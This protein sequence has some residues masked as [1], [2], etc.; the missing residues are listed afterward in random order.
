MTKTATIYALSTATGRGAVAI[1]RLSGPLALSALVT[2]GV[3]KEGY[4]PRMATRVV[5]RDPATGQ[6]LDDA[7]ATYFR[8]PNSF[9]GEDVVELH[10]HGGRAVVEGVLSA[11]AKIEGLRLAEAGEFTR[12]AFEHGKLDLT[13][14]EAVADLINAETQA[15]RELALDQLGGSLA[16]LYTGFSTQLAGALAHLEADIEFPDEDLPAGVSHAVTGVVQ[17][18]LGEITAHLSDARRGERLRDGLRIAIIGAPNAGKSSLLNA[19]ARRDAAIVSPTAGTTRDVIEVALDLGG[20][21]VVLADTAGLR[22][23][24]DEIE[25]EGIKRARKN[26][27]EADIVLAL[28]DGT[29]DK[30]AATLNEIDER[31]IQVLTKSDLLTTPPVDTLAISTMTGAGIDRLLEILTTRVRDSL[32]TR[33]GPVLTRARHREALGEAQAHLQRAV[34]QVET[35]GLPELIAEDLRM[36]LRAL[37]RITGKVHVEDLL[38]KIFRDFC[39]GK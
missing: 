22:I 20:Y 12:R 8:G 18:L 6:K 11:L 9:T 13:A 16:R 15:Q 34:A 25:S 38:D 10:L 24:D 2:L 36:A 39:I 3:G 1:V 23:S 33:Q 31:T 30:D 19:L 32:M 14:A 5:L 37:G 29:S 17:K 28:F 27:E 7:L 4:L 21:P 35:S 26:A